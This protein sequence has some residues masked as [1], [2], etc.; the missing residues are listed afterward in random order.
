MRVVDRAELLKLPAGTIFRQCDPYTWDGEWQRLYAPC[1]E[2]DFFASVIG[3]QWRTGVKCE[4]TIDSGVCRDGRLDRA[5]QYVV[6]DA[7]D[8]ALIVKQLLGTD[9]ENEERVL[10]VKDLP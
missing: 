5:P 4:L 7:G 10:D 3:P 2:I 9:R 8:I 1:G 6:L